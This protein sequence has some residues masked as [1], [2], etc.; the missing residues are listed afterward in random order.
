[1]SV[2]QFIEPDG[3]FLAPEPLNSLAVSIVDALS[4]LEGERC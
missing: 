4:C 2:H 3:A 1:M